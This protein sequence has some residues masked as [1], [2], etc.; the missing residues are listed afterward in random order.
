ME[1]AFTQI[2]SAFI[3]KLHEKCISTLTCSRKRDSDGKIIEYRQNS[4]IKE[5][6]KIMNDKDQFICFLS[7]A[8]GA[9]KSKVIHT[10]RY[11]YKK[12][13]EQLNIQFTKRT[14]VVV[15]AMTGAAA[16]GIMEK[17]LTKHA[18]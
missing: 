1:I 17:Q 6:K 14:I 11:Y 12:L 10:V 7:G 15:I 9:G 2:V 18:V 5:L 3:L 13:C 4:K 8:G 16:V